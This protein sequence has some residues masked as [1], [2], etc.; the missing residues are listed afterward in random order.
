ME[1]RS[2]EIPRQFTYLPSSIS[3]DCNERRPCFRRR[4]HHHHFVSVLF[5]IFFCLF[6]PFLFFSS[7]SC[8]GGY[9]SGSKHRGNGHRRTK[10][11][12]TD[13]W[14]GSRALLLLC[15]VDSLK[16][17]VSWVERPAT[18]VYALAAHGRCG[19]LFLFFSLSSPPFHLS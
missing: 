11:K 10:I 2:R 18:S 4:S 6:G 16:K 9:N 15:V 19:F 7:F 17:R 3:T 5:I 14:D 1:V 12:V 13:G 8:L